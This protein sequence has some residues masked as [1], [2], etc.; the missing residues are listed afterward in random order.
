[1]V[2]HE[3]PYSTTTSSLIDSILKANDKGKIKIKK[4]E[5]NTAAEVEIL[6]HLPNGISPDKTIDALY[7]FTACESSISP[8]GCIIIDNKP[9]FI[10]VLEM[11]K[12]STDTTVSTLKKELEHRLQE[13]ENQWHYASLERIFIENKVYRLIEE[14]ETWEGCSKP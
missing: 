11:L 12:I 9:N 14:E 2:I 13:L 8:L 1:M 3:I 5:D 10:G 4:I 6:V 7:A